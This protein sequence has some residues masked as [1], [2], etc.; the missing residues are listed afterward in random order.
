MMRLLLLVIDLLL[1]VSQGLCQQPDPEIETVFEEKVAVWK[2]WVNE[3]TNSSDL[4]SCKEF[5]DIVAL[6][7]KVVPLLIKKIQEDKSNFLF[8]SAIESITQVRIPKEKWP[9]GRMGGSISAV[10]VYQ[11]WWHEDRKNT[12]QTYH[13]LKSQWDEL[14]ASPD[15]ERTEIGLPL[16]WYDQTVYDAR[17]GSLLVFGRPHITELGRVYISVEGLGIDILPLIIID[18]ANKRYDFLSIFMRMTQFHVDRAKN[19]GDQADDIL[20]WW[21]IHKEEW[22]M[23]E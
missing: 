12:E 15:I 14:K 8:T 7:P 21:N 16:L 20:A 4:T 1:C 18:L 2:T 5:K 13:A 23:P 6:G 10:N 17:S 9:E 19:I 22:M 11:I 3:H